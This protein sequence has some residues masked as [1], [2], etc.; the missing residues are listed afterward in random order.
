MDLPGNREWTIVIQS[1][2]E[3]LLRDKISSCQKVTEPELKPEI[4]K[5][6]YVQKQDTLAVDEGAQLAALKDVSSERRKIGQLGRVGTHHNKDT[7]RCGKM[8]HNA[9]KGEEKL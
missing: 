4:Q 9:R 2:N 3:L 7:G 8:G 5:R 6:R 1:V